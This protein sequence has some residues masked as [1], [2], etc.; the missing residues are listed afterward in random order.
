MAW[1][2]TIK[3][4]EQE[5]PEAPKEGSSWKNSIT[6]IEGESKTPNADAIANRLSD[7]AS[8][9]PAVAAANYIGEKMPTVSDAALGA[10]EGA[11]LGFR[12]KYLG[13]VKALGK[14]ALEGLTGE[15]PGGVSNAYE[16]LLNNYK[17]YK[18]Q[19]DVK[20]DE[21]H[22][23]SPIISGAEKLAGN[24]ITGGAALKGA[25]ALGLG[26]EGIALSRQSVP[27]AARL[28]DAAASIPAAA[29]LGA[30]QGAGE[31]KEGEMGSGAATGALAGGLGGVVG[32]QIIGPAVAAGANKLLTSIGN[33]SGGKQLAATLLNASKGGSLF[34]EPGTGAVTTSTENL[35]NNTANELTKGVE[36]KNA[37][38]SNAWTKSAQNGE[39]LA[40]PSAEELSSISDVEP[41]LNKLGYEDQ[42]QALKSGEMTPKQANDFRS[43]LKS[44]V[45]ALYNDP[46][47]MTKQVSRN[48]A[49]EIQDSGLFTTPLKN[50]GGETI[51][52]NLGLLEKKSAQAGTDIQALNQSK[53]DAW[54]QLEPFI[55]KANKVLPPEQ[56]VVNAADMPL[57]QARQKIATMMQ[58]LAQKSGLSTG[59]GDEARNTLQNMQQVLQDV[60]SSTNLGINPSQI[61]SNIQNQGY[62][63]AAKT[64]VTG[65]QQSKLNPAKYLDFINPYRAAEKLSGSKTAQDISSRLLGK[66]PLQ[67]RAAAD[68]LSQNPKTRGLAEQLVTAHSLNDS[69]KMTNT[70]FQILQNPDAK[71]ALKKGANKVM[72]S[73]PVVVNSDT[74]EVNK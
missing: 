38:F 1:Q 53:A 46:N 11:S 32:E 25:Q 17:K 10:Q 45:N 48:V 56:Q 49:E 20:T 57:E 69:Q 14:T 23:R 42:V 54:K 62:L 34:T 24:F 74:V 19:E 4:I 35:A 7:L 72:S 36:A 66:D 6:P 61:A 59:I 70:A 12:N 26:G 37:D 60:N 31:A 27:L 52:N 3:P 67:M 39:K 16:E 58:G 29:A 18:G 5:T 73:I 15:I 9:H 41:T 71:E 64:G 8:Y 2:D 21:A 65:I 28:S 63:N 33:T 47:P 50:E 40:A 30:V 51:G 43:Q 22:K 13:G 55:Q 68:A 44:H